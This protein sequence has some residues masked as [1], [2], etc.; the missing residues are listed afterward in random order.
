MTRDDDIAFLE[1]LREKID[2]YLFLGFAPSEGGIRF[3][4]G[5]DEMRQARNKPE[6]ERLH[7]EINQMTRRG[8]QLL[9]EAGAT[10]QIGERPAPII[11][12]PTTT[13]D[14]LNL[15]TRNGTSFRMDKFQ[16]MDPI[17]QAIG[18]LK[19]ADESSESIHSSPQLVRQTVRGTV[20]IAMPMTEGD[21]QLDDVHDAIKMCAESLSLTA[22]RID[23]LQSNERITDRVME[24]LE[25]AEFIVSDL[26]HARPNVYF[27]AGYS[28]GLNKLPIYIARQGT[29][30]EFDLKDYPVLFFKNLVELKQKLTARLEELMTG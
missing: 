11:G 1:S 16:F 13:F 27:E 3:G 28:Q 22:T 14:L 15:V 18:W 23:D 26:T 7:R 2:K 20:F 10:N 24:A 21:P 25:S 17:D 8:Q 4:S 5:V 12:G 19:E 29:E 30:I 9:G 6:I